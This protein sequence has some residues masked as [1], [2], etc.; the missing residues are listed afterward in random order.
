MNSIERLQRA[1]LVMVVAV[2]VLL[3]FASIVSRL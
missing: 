2:L 3:L 1:E